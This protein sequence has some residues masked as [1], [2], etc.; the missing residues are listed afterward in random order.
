MK[1]Q[2]T[3]KFKITQTHQPMPVNF[4]FEAGLDGVNVI[5]GSISKCCLAYNWNFS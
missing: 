5:Q 1:M 4:V 3:A 2:I